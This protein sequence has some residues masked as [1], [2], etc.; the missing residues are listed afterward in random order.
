MPG[1]RQEGFTEFGVYRHARIPGGYRIYADSSAP[2]PATTDGILFANGSNAILLENDNTTVHYIGVKAL[3][4]GPVKQ[5]QIIASALGTFTVL[6]PKLEY[7][8]R[9]APFEGVRARAL[10][11]GV[12]SGAAAVSAQQ[13]F[14]GAAPMSGHYRISSYASLSRT[15]NGRTRPHYGVDLAPIPAGATDRKALAVVDGVIRHHLSDPGGYGHALEL[16][17]SDGVVY[18]YAHLKA[19]SFM[20]PNNGQVKQGQPIATVGSTGASTGVHLHFEVRRVPK[21]VQW[22]HDTN[23]YVQ[24]MPLEGRIKGTESVT[25]IV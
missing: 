9:S 23:T 3:T 4:S 8:D 25:G 7:A 13:L 24:G 15:I 12:R 11:T 2:V 18:F 17:G 5:G 1:N 14:A 20:V 22:V 21:K 16:H 19:G 10:K 6:D